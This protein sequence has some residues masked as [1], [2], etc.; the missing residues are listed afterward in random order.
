MKLPKA[1]PRAI[2]GRF[3]SVGKDDYI[4]VVSSS[5]GKTGMTGKVVE[6]YDNNTVKAF[7]GDKVGVRSYRA[8]SYRV[9]SKKAK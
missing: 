6:V 4:E 7:F 9:V 2:D 8:G 5:S 3:D 1:Q